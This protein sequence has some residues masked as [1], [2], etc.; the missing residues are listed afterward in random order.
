MTAL[1]GTRRKATSRFRD[2]ASSGGCT[3]SY[4]GMFC[5]SV[6]A[7]SPILQHYK[8]PI[9]NAGITVLVGLSPFI[10]LKLLLKLRTPNLMHMGAIA[11]LML[12]YLYKV[13]SHDTSLLEVMHAAVMVMYFIAVAS[14]CI[15][16]IYFVKIASVVAA[17]ASILLLLQYVCFYMLGFHLQLIPTN[18]L[19]LESEQW[20][21]GAQ[22]GM[23]GITGQYNSFYRPSA[24]FL[25]PSHLFIYVMPLLCMLLLAPDMRPWRLQLALLLTAGIFLS[26]SGM[27]I[28]VGTGLWMLYGGMYRGNGNIPR[29]TK[30][31]TPTNIIIVVTVMLA[32]VLFYC[33][34]AFFNQSINRILGIDS[35]E[36]DAISGRVRLASEFAKTLTGSALWFGMKD[37]LG[38]VEFNLSGYYATLFKYGIIGTFLSYVFYAQ[39][40]LK[41]KAQYFWLSFVIILISFFTAHTHGTFYMLYFVV[42]LMAGYH[43]KNRSRQGAP[44]ERLPHPLPRRVA[45]ASR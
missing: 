23:A 11:P 22:T 34:V 18:L 44:C 3:D 36:T 30:L 5:A 31:F 35:D 16:R 32:L 33:N 38:E 1:T 9:G 42:I 15:N 6:L 26:T 17:S 37:S 41:L 21:L 4:I 19:L 45:I 40:L 25:E 39:S 13:L 24:F 14:G 27:G 7:I 43:E 2:L 20:V 29:I 28:G 8:G 12:F 10:Y